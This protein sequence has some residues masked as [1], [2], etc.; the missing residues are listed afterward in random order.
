MAAALV[1]TVGYLLGSVPFAFLLARR[2]GVDLRR[3]GSG[4]IGAANVLR[5]T[6]VAYAV[7]A[8]CLDAAKGAV[9]VLLA[10][11][12]NG[13]L[14][15]SVSAGLAAI[16][17][18]V[19]PIWLG[20]RGGK[21]VAT[22]AGAFAVLSPVALGIAATI[23]LVVVGITRYISVG[24]TAASVALAVVAIVGDLPRSVVLGAAA[25]ALIIVHR[26]RANFARVVA[27]TERRIGQRA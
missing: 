26:H 12:L 15:V 21:G 27:G 9:A 2:R 4:N 5:T 13:E 23:F 6:S 20:F 24:S 16:I 18:H 3:A 25:A 10:Q 8:V 11:R 17:G 7:G 22:A 14:A 1:V 19:Y